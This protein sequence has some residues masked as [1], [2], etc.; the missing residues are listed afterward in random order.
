MANCTITFFDQF[1][2]ALSTTILLVVLQLLFFFLHSYWER[3]CHA[4]EEVFSGASDAHD[5]KAHA[6][7]RLFMPFWNSVGCWALVLCPCVLLE[8][9]VGS[10]VGPIEHRSAE[11]RRSVEMFSNPFWV[12]LLSGGSATLL[13]FRW[14]TA[15]MY[16]I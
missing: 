3:F 8:G 16:S 14:E 1:L 13:H 5:G 7:M 6:C 11:C 10:F 4:V 9:G 2:I 15:L 12:V